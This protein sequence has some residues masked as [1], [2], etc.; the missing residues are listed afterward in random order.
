MKIESL[1]VSPDAIPT[2]TRRPARKMALAL[3]ALVGLAACAVPSLRAARVSP[4]EALR[5]E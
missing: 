2:A 1:P 3:L 5:D 4:M